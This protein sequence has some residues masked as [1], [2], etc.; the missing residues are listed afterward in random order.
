MPVWAVVG[1]LIMSERAAGRVPAPSSLTGEVFGNLLL[2]FSWQPPSGWDPRTLSNSTLD[3]YK[4]YLSEGNQDDFSSLVTLTYFSNF[5]YVSSPFV[6]KPGVRYYLRVISVTCC[7]MFRFHIKCADAR[8]NGATCEESATSFHCTSTDG[9]ETCHYPQD[10]YAEA[11]VVAMREPG[12]PEKADVLIAASTGAYPGAPH[13]TLQWNLPNET[14]T[15]QRQRVDVQKFKVIRATDSNFTSSTQIFFGLPAH[16]GTTEDTYQYKVTDGD[17]LVAGTTYFYRIYTKNAACGPADITCSPYIVASRNASGYPSEPTAIVGELLDSTRI[18]LDW[19]LPAD[20]GQGGGQVDS[21]YEP[22]TGYRIYQDYCQPAGQCSV[23]ASNY[24]ELHTS[25]DPSTLTFLKTGIDGAYTFVFYL[26]AQNGAGWGTMG[27]VEVISLFFPSAPQSF[28]AEITAALTIKLTWSTPDNTGQGANDQT[29]AITGY[30]LYQADTVNVFNDSNAI[31][32]Q[33]GIFFTKTISFPQKRITP[34]CFMV[35]AANQLGYAPDNRTMSAFVCEYAVDVPTKPTDLTAKVVGEKQIKLEWVA[36]T[37]TGVGDSSR[38]LV[39]F[40]L[41][42]STSSS[43]DNPQESELG[44]LLTTHTVTVPDSGPEPFYFRIAAFNEVGQSQF[45]TSANEQGITVPSTP[46]NLVATIPE[47]RQITINWAGPSDTGI[48]SAGRALLQYR[49]EY[50]EAGGNA[51]TQYFNITTTTSVYMNLDYTKS[52]TFRVYV[53]NDAGWSAYAEVTER[54][55]VLPTVPINFAASV[56]EPLKIRLKWERPT[57][58]GRGGHFEPISE[59]YVE[60]DSG[61]A[62]GGTADFAA[63]TEKYRGLTACDGT[64]CTH[65]VSFTAA[66]KDPYW[67][68]VFA[69]NQLGTGPGAVTNEQSVQ[70]PSAPTGLTVIVIAPRTVFLTWVQPADTGVGTDPVRALYNYTLEQSYQDSTFQDGDNLVSRSFLNNTFNATIVLP[71]SGPTY[72]FF[73]V[74]TS[75]DAGNSQ[76]SSIVQEQ[77]VEVP[78]API[79]LATSINASLEIRFH[80]EMPTNTGVTGQS[81]PLESYILEVAEE[82]GRA[83]SSAFSP[84]WF[85]DDNVSQ[86]NQATTLSRLFTGLDKGKTYFFRVAARNIAGTGPFAAFVSNDAITQ[87]ASPI[88]LTAIVDTPFEIDLQWVQPPDNGFNENS[89]SKLIRFELEQSLVSDFATGVSSNLLPTNFSTS[90]TFSAPDNTKGQRHYFRIWAVNQAGR[91][92]VPTVV[93][94]EAID[95]PSTPRELSISITDE[96]E[97]TTVWNIP[98]DTGLGAGVTP[99]RPLNNYF[100]QVFMSDTPPTGSTCTWTESCSG[101]GSPFGTACSSPAGCD[102]TGF[103]SLNPDFTYTFPNTTYTYV[104]SGLVK[105]KTYFVRVVASNDAGTGAV[106]A[107]VNKPAL[108]RPN[109]P[110]SLTVLA[111]RPLAINF[112][113]AISTDTGLGSS[114]MPP[115]PMQD[116]RI[117]VATDAAFTQNV[118]NLS[119]NPSITNHV[120]T[121]LTKGLHYHIRIFSN[122]MLGESA[123][124]NKLTEHAIDV[125]TMPLNLSVLVSTSSARDLVLT[126]QFPSD[127]GLGG[128]ACHDKCLGGE[129]EL[130]QLRIQRI[131]T[132][133][134]AET[135]VA[136]SPQSAPAGTVD[137]TGHHSIVF[138]P[139]SG[140]WSTDHYLPLGYTDENLIKGMTYYYAVVA[141]N[142]AGEGIASAPVFEMALDSPLPPR[143][144][145]VVIAGELTLNTSWLEPLDNGDG[146]VTDLSAPRP[147]IKYRVE[148]DEV[149]ATVVFEPAYNWVTNPTASK[150]GLTA[151]VYPERTAFTVDFAFDLAFPTLE[152]QALAPML[153]QGRMYYFRVVALNAHS[154]SIPS[155][156]ANLTAILRPTA[157][158]VTAASAIVTNPAEITFTWYRPRDTGAIGQYW[159]LKYFD[160]Q[161]SSGSDENFTDATTNVELFKSNVIDVPAS[162]S[163][164]PSGVN[165]SID[166]VTAYVFVV[167][168]LTVGET[169]YFRVFTENEAGQSEASPVITKI[170]VKLPT[171]P[172]NF[173]LTVTGEL[174]ILVKWNT[175]EDTGAGG[176]LKPIDQYVLEFEVGDITTELSTNF[177]LSPFASDGCFASKQPPC[178]LGEGVSPY[179]VGITINGIGSSGVVYDSAANCLPKVD[180]ASGQLLN[181]PSV[182]HPYMMGSISA[183]P[184]S[185]LNCNSYARNYDAVLEEWSV[186][187]TGLTKART[188]WFRVLALNDAGLSLPS[189]ILHEFGVALPSAPWGPPVPNIPLQQRVRFDII[190]ILTYRIRFSKPFDTGLGDQR[191]EL[192]SYGVQLVSF[193]D[194]NAL[195]WGPHDGSA[196][197]AYVGGNELFADVQNGVNNVTILPGLRYFA[198]VFAVNSAGPGDFS[199][200]DSNGPSFDYFEPNFGPSAGGSTVFVVGSRMGD[201]SSTFQMFIGDQECLSVFP[202]RFQTSVGCIVPPGLPGKVGFRLYVDGL[203]MKKDS[204]F[205]YL[206]PKIEYVDPSDGVS[207]EGGV[208]VSVWGQN[209]G[210][211]PAGQEIAIASERSDRCRE[212]AW[213]SDSA[214]LCVTAAV[215]YGAKENNT[216]IVRSNGAASVPWARGSSLIYD[217]PAHYDCSRNN[218][219]DC[220][221]CAFTSCHQQLLDRAN[222]KGTE[223]AGRPLAAGEVSEVCEGLVMEYCGYTLVGAGSA[224]DIT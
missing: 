28:Q 197:V 176:R 121:G 215:P 18:R 100:L 92:L 165:T 69:V 50:F 76:I 116:Q 107:A 218:A 195:L 180:P 150:V 112:T 59:Y 54:P 20:T 84:L 185:G 143:D 219:A 53:Q 30:K 81:R 181:V 58:T 124:S 130:T 198:R 220:Y 13:L 146:L 216:V 191:R 120:I 135:V 201:A 88:S 193:E 188:Y 3:Q 211:K 118:F 8:A 98:A 40:V 186:L 123:A 101:E 90:L 164:G 57:N 192:V 21:P 103:A 209:F 89:L 99:I 95:V 223:F 167:S 29:E 111:D 6:S 128:S 78:S 177:S 140:T 213:T 194:E 224:G 96:L 117:Q 173:T 221:A 102:W 70:V 208:R 168:D 132:T 204:V 56:H 77:G 14:G 156:V 71:S 161:M 131:N 217:V 108:S 36:P 65:D 115:W 160:L 136:V 142:T 79:G 200:Y 145:S 91:S 178:A 82:E 74:Y 9:V 45:S 114:I 1:L 85:F 152:Y 138:E 110:T 214:M 43:F 148:I 52:Y 41:Q 212:I 27:T 48:G 174:Q 83:D 170:A 159:P 86:A 67:F 72:F 42:V 47:E 35:Q 222:V 202:A 154:W 93:S 127:T 133:N 46:T 105:G 34:Y 5:Q 31:L 196:T 158:I 16:T 134:P 182:A 126:W 60:M 184:N 205:E 199:G 139:S 169:Y 66:R 151:P 39:K 129:R 137:F 94:E 15:G 55:I 179:D 75:N 153:K 157:P 144:L 155:T 44:P 163:T 24:G 147:L 80:W 73:R 125:P 106:S 149:E 119:I 32:L 38:P 37:D 68:R 62:F 162:R 4:V 189:P 10:G 64:L 12:A 22:I 175:P 19:Q 2:K 11:S 87:P 25:N 166:L 49:V 17:S 61:V 7:S 122:N 206:P 97:L 26:Q 187:I 104:M 63:V 171:A 109:A 113:W 33:T 207:V 190:G 210:T 23:D 172:A 51:T 141:S 183:G 203:L